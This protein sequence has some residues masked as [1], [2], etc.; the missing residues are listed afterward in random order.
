MWKTIITRNTGTQETRGDE[1]YKLK[2]K[3]NHCHGHTPQIQ[4][5]AKT[6]NSGVKRMPFVTWSSTSCNRWTKQKA[7]NEGTAWGKTASDRQ[8]WKALVEGLHPAVDRQCR[9]ME[10][11]GTEHNRQTAT[12]GFGGVLHPAVDG[13]SSRRRMREPPKAGQH[14]TDSNGR[15]WWGVYILQ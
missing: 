7:K 3:Q 2:P 10:P 11:P 15:R 12:V 13:Q 1:D 14:Q 9:R 8:Q 4:K 5:G 6:S